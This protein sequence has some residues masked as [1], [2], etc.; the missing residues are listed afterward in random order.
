M[1]ISIFI[2]ISF[3]L[4]SAI[5]STTIG[6]LTTNYLTNPLGIDVI[7]RFSWI[8]RESDG[9]KDLHQVSYDLQIS[10]T[11]DFK[12]MLIDTT[13]NTKQ[14][15]LNT[16]TNLTMDMF[17]PSSD[18]FWRVSAKLSDGNSSGFSDPASF[19]TGLMQKWPSTATWITGG[20]SNKL[21]RTIFP[22]PSVGFKQAKL[23]ISGIGYHEV[24]INGEKVGDHKLDSPWSDNNHRNYYVTHDVT[25]LL[26][27]SDMNAIGI[28]LGNG[29]YS[30]GDSS[31]PTTQPGC[32]SD[33]PQVIATLVVDGDVSNPLIST[34]TSWSVSSGPITYDSLYNGE[35]YDATK[36]KE[37]WSTF[38]FDDSKWS[39]ALDASSYA[40]SK[41]GKL[42]SAMFEPIRVVSA[43]D[44]VT[45]TSP[46]PS[47]SVFDFGQNMAGIVR[48]SNLFC[49]SGD[50]IT[51]R[52]SELMMHPPYGP[53]NGS[54]Y[55]GNLRGAE[56]TDTYTCKGDPNG[57]MYEPRFTQH[58]FRF[59]EVTADASYEIQA[60]E[61]HTDVT[62]HSTQTHAN[63]LLN[64]IQNAVIWGQKSNLMS[65]PTDCPQRDERRGWSGDAA[66]TSEE[67]SINF[68]M[69]AFYTAYL[70]QI[71]DDQQPDGAVTNFVPSLGSGDGAPN[72][73]S[74]YPSIV[75]AMMMYYGD[76][77]P[78]HDHLDSLRAYYNY[79][80]TG[81]N[82]TGMK[83][84]A[85]GFGDWVPPPPAPKADG[86]F[87]GAFSFLHDLKMGSSFFAAAGYAQDAKHLQDLF[88]S[89][90]SQ[91]HDAFFN[92]TKFLTGLQTENA[93]PLY[94]DI[95]P[96]SVKSQVLD[97]LVNDIVHTNDL[98]TTC[99]IVGIRCLLEALTFHNKS[100]VAF[101]MIATVDTYPSYGYMIQGEGNYEP[102]TTIWELWDS[103]KEGPGMNSRNHIM[104]GTVSAWMTKYLLGVRP[105]SSGYET[106]TIAPSSVGRSNYTH[107]S[108][109]VRTPM[110]DISSSWKVESDGSV[111]HD[112][113][114]P[115][116]ATATIRVAST[117]E[118]YIR[119]S[120]VHSF[121]VEKDGS[122]LAL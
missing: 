92:G 50:V 80:E 21:L 88:E 95:V 17:K 48:L 11:E 41:N 55:Y 12:N 78:V 79:L 4:S 109:V 105:T 53:R 85:S 83:N 58:G 70:N 37:G 119:G 24:Y 66:L 44:P 52:H 9:S 113:K 87:L 115:I 84:F 27:S 121:R 13:E 42:V 91:F 122:V 8:L 62:Q 7:P 86:H 57:E 23:F 94:L 69:G 43:R 29:W 25:S 90:S 5:S 110:G 16:P 116:G 60:L 104:F 2:F 51:I 35:R 75:Y 31:H 18:Y 38:S 67:A 10:S 89:S 74:V 73:Q 19:S 106:F 15:Y 100:D 97:Y 112:V 118:T 3:L 102:A 26:S 39:K 49:N 71:Q 120:G 14:N 30:C 45:I 111:S 28:M 96:S 64:K 114:I 56:A 63:D 68:A 117:E 47:V 98:H 101:D 77:Q 36:E 65:V 32:V 81:L 72:W 103:D 61:M 108:T 93:L 6:E 107:A 20:I 40:A 99:G 54:L 46:T 22:S 82:K 34:S 59:A 1:K 76:V 33:P